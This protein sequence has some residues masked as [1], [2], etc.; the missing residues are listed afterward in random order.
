MSSNFSK[1]FSLSAAIIAATSSSVLADHSELPMVFN[2]A[3]CSV[4]NKA[5]ALLTS[6][7]LSIGFEKSERNQKIILKSSFSEPTAELVDAKKIDKMISIIDAK[8]KEGQHLV[9][10]FPALTEIAPHLNKDQVLGV[11][12]QK[13]KLR[14]Y[15]STQ[16]VRPVLVKAKA[17]ISEFD[18]TPKNKVTKEANQAMLG[19]PQLPNIVWKDV[20]PNTA[21]VL[22]PHAE[23]AHK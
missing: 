3:V 23:F 13:L 10:A 4:D 5:M 18:C 1:V 8:Y 12:V 21:T 22:Y 14:N 17:T 19:L 6:A 20:S 11:A 15:I 7:S 16:M 9:S 2:S